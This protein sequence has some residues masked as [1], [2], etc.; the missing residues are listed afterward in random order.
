MSSEPLLALHGAVLHPGGRT[1]IGGVNLTVHPG[2]IVAIRG[3]SGG[4]K[5]SALRAVAGLVPVVKG[6][7]SLRAHR[8]GVM[9]QEPRLLPWRTVLE[10]VLF[11]L[12]RAP[13]AEHTEHAV[14]LLERLGVADVRDE[15]PAALSGG[16]RH[17][18]GIARALLLDAD[19]LLADE[20]FAHL[21]EIW[22]GVVADVLTERAAAGAG[23][24]L[25][26]HEIDLVDR[27]AHRVQ[28]LHGG[29]VDKRDS[30]RTT[31]TAGTASDRPPRGQDPPATPAPGR[32]HRRR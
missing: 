26:A 25:A 21:D 13:D 4:G 28:D 17:R 29:K 1:R 20:P 12:G 23:V 18:V 14:V 22:A 31:I 24:L 2:E 19:L 5:T 11:V 9:F 30:R 15:L 7:F 27:V 16:M 3:P 6:E 32:A 10:N 8:I